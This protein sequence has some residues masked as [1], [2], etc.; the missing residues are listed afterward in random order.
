MLDLVYGILAGVVAL[1]VMVAVGLVGG[2]AICLLGD[3]I[4]TGLVWAKDAIRAWFK[5]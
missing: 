4:I 2:M 1:G 3:L 5:K